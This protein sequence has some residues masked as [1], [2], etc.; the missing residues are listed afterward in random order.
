MSWFSV[1]ERFIRT[2]TCASSSW[3]GEA[4]PTKGRIHLRRLTLRPTTLLLQ[5]GGGPYIT[6]SNLLRPATFEYDTLRE[7]PRYVSYRSSSG[8]GD[9]CSDCFWSGAKRQVRLGTSSIRAEPLRW[10][11]RPCA[12]TRDKATRSRILHAG[13]RCCLWP[14]NELYREFLDRSKAHPA[15][16]NCVVAS[17]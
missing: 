17:I 15:D 12:Y 10:H 13:G 9:C 7:T 2:G 4:S 1:T 14:T 8:V 11:R 6:N 5:S 3:P 16:S